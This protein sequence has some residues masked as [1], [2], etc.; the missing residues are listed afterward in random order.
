MLACTRLL[1]S[2]SSPCTVN[3][4]LELQT[5]ASGSHCWDLYIAVSGAACF[6]HL[7]LKWQADNRVVETSYHSVLWRIGAW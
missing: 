2:T 5:F 4:T 7:G 6:Q 3:T 1:Q